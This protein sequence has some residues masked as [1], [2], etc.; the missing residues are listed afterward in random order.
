MAEELKN[1][2]SKLLDRYRLSEP[3]A[4]FDII[5]SWEKIMGKVIA[6]RTTKVFIRNKK[7]YIYLDSAVLRNEMLYAKE[8]V[9]KLVNEHAGKLL[10]EEVIIY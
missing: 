4:S 10:V 1:T 6:S 9:I 2:L 7:L 5:D 3:L 8:M